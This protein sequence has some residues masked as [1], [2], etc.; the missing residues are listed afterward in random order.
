MFDPLM[1]ERHLLSTNLCGCYISNFD[2]AK[3][4]KSCDIELDL[5][6]RAKML[7]LLLKKAHQEDKIQ[8]LTQTL[9]AFLANRASKFS[10]Y[11]QNPIFAEQLHK[12]RATQQLLARFAHA[13][14]N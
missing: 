7:K 13:P 5:T 11:P 1:I 6:D 8:L 10:R 3:I 12:I 4:A 14:L 9:I 2:L